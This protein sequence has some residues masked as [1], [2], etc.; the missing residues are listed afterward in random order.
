MLTLEIIDSGDLKISVDDWQVFREELDELL[1]K[2]LDDENIMAELLGSTVDGTG[3]HLGNGWTLLPNDVAGVNLYDYR[4]QLI[5]TQ[6]CLPDDDDEFTLK[7]GDVVYNYE[8]PVKAPLDEL[9]KHGKIILKRYIAE[10]V[11]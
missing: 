11:A 8:E 5:L 3:G 4:T 9:C 1:G 6:E 7:A 2:D 10:G